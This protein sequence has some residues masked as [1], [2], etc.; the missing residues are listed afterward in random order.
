MKKPI[1]IVIKTKP[2][3]IRMGSPYSY[4]ELEFIGT[5]LELPTSDWQNKFT[6]SLDN[7]WLVLIRFDLINNNP[8]FR[9]Y[10]IDTINDSLQVSKRI[11]GMVDSIRIDKN[12][13][14]YNKFLLNRDKSTREKL[15][16]HTNEEYLIQNN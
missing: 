13:I 5:E 4:C 1:E 9:F 16:C 15:C 12:T 7:N 3:E 6:W 10:I 11:L 14:L 2:S 8:G